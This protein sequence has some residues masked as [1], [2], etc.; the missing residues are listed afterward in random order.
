MRFTGC[1]DLRVFLLLLEA[2]GLTPSQGN[3]IDDEVQRLKRDL[4]F[5]GRFIRDYECNLYYQDA[6]VKLIFSFR[7]IHN[8]EI[9]MYEKEKKEN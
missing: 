5:R 3:S 8:Y 9:S 1:R 7:K 6:I 4:S 2:R